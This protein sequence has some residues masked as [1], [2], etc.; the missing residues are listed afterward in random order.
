[1]DTI[2][3]GFGSI[4]AYLAPY[5]VTATDLDALRSNLLA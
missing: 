2:L 3:T 4:P 1:M 5:G